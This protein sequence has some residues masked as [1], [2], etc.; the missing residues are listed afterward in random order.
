MGCDCWDSA[1]VTHRFTRQGLRGI[2]WLAGR[3]GSTDHKSAGRALLLSN[4]GYTESFLQRAGMPLCPDSPTDQRVCWHHTRWGCGCTSAPGRYLHRHGDGTHG[5]AA[6]TGLEGRVQRGLGSGSRRY[7]WGRGRGE[8]TT[9]AWLRVQAG[10]RPGGAAGA[11]ERPDGRAGRASPS[12][13]ARD[14]RTAA[15]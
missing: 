6:R 4:L 14:D 10:C 13:G 15:W 9:L 12:H 5:R 11:C 7:M 1:G 8:S 2:L 3:Q